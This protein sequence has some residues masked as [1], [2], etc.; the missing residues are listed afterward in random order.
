VAPVQRERDTDF[1]RA[2]EQKQ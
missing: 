2:R 1:A